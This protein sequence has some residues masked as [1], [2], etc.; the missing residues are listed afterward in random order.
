MKFTHKY[1]KELEKIL[2]KAAKNPRLLHEFLQDLLSPPE[3]EDLAIRWQIVRQLHKNVPQRK[4]A[5]NLRV[6]VATVS[7]GSR[8]L[9]NKKGGFTKMIGKK[10][11]KDIC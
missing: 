9:L 11:T 5:K 8:E 7:R 6:S 10:I 2:Q 1:G 4:I 3:Y